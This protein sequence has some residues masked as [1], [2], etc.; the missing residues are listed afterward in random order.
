MKVS[1]QRSIRFSKLDP[2]SSYFLLSTKNNGFFRS[3][4]VDRID[5][6][7]KPIKIAW[8]TVSP[9]HTFLIIP[10]IIQLFEIYK[11][12]CSEYSTPSISTHL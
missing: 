2:S 7:A 6:W 12:P 8:L 10:S 3:I 9:T 5:A 11:A 4:G 1:P